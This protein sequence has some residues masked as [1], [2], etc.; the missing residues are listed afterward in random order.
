MRDSKRKNT[1]NLSKTNAAI[2]EALEKS[3]LIVCII[4]DY[5]HFHAIKRPDSEQTSSGTD[6]CTTGIRI[7]PSIRAL[8]RNNVSNAHNPEGV[9]NNH[10]TATICSDE[11]LT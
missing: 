11:S 1:E 10:L 2:S 7:F 5:H 6:M 8:P 3:Y 9:T 4:D